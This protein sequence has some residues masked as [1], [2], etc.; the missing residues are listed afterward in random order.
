MVLVPV[1]GG[2]SRHCWGSGGSGSAPSGDRSLHPSPSETQLPPSG[3]EGPERPSLAVRGEAAGGR[4][5]GSC[6]GAGGTAP[7]AVPIS[8]RAA[9]RAA[10]A[11]ALG[12]PVRQPEAPPSQEARVHVCPKVCASSLCRSHVC[13]HLRSIPSVRPPLPLSA[14]PLCPSAPRLPARA[15]HRSVRSPLALWVLVV[16][17]VFVKV[18]IDSRGEWAPGSSPAPSPSLPCAPSPCSPVPLSPAWTRA[19][20]APSS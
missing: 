13:V 8:R 12:L 9:G 20:A 3:R 16:V 6:G 2:K 11:M 5:H 14:H 15:G 19:P 18:S 1:T 10:R 7:C 4:S 17:A